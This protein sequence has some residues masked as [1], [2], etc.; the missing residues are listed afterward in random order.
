M[1]YKSYK[2]K[3]LRCDFSVIYLEGDS[4]VTIREDIFA[5]TNKFNYLGSI[6]QSNRKICDKKFLIKLKSQFYRVVI[7]PK[8]LCR[9]NCWPVKKNFEQRMKVLEMDM[10]W[11]KDQYAIIKLEYIIYFITLSHSENREQFSAKYSM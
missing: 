4:E 8:L 5:C 10:W 7:E 11:N 9:I 2:N 3:Y 1:A 6:L